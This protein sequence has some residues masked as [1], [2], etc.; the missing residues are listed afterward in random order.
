M[1]KDMQVDWDSSDAANCWGDLDAMGHTKGIPR[2]GMEE[3]IAASW[4]CLTEE[5]AVG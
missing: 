5:Q 2:A 3:I 4:T 1:G